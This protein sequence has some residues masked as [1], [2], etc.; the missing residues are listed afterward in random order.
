MAHRAS[1][2]YT[3]S[4]LYEAVTN[5]ATIGDAVP[6]SLSVSVV[7]A[8]I[9]VV[10]L[11]AESVVSTIFVKR[12]DSLRMLTRLFSVRVGSMVCGGGY[13]N[14]MFE[15]CGSLVYGATLMLV[16]CVCISVC[17]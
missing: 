12:T 13:G 1:A 14:W 8:M 9:G 7:P 4:M 3:N 5:G 16:M 2:S 15:R 6:D 11:V 10:V 17:V